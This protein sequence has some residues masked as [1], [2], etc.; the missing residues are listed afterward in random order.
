MRVITKLSTVRPDIASG[1][2]PSTMPCVTVPASN[3]SELAIRRG[4]SSKVANALSLGDFKTLENYYSLHSQRTSRTPSGRWDLQFFYDGV[5]FN[6]PNNKK[7]GGMFEAQLQRW[8]QEYPQSPAPHIAYSQFLIRRGWIF[9]GGGYAREVPRE[10]WAP[11]HENIEL[12]RVHLEQTEAFASADPQWYV[13]MFLVAKA[14]S[15]SQLEVKMLFQEALSK[16]AYYLETYQTIFDNL[17][18]KWG[19]S[20]GEAEDFAN[21]ATTITSECEGQGM[22]TRIYWRAIDSNSDFRNKPFENSYVNWEMMKMGFE[23]IVTRYPTAWN[24]NSFAR[25]ACLAQDKETTRR[26][27]DQIGDNPALEAWTEKTT[28]PGCKAWASAH[29]S[30]LQFSRSW[31]N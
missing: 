27:I 13:T 28:F 15:W 18:P 10:A 7:D 6:H 23:D 20:F 21:D 25:F 26:L 19:G 9:R 29:S 8:M 5:D 22:Y 24:I 17:T 16:E 3:E 2:P 31:I 4:I 14:Q 30:N 1:I 12:A 11:F